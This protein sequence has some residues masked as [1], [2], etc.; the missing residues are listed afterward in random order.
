M[1]PH[2]AIDANYIGCQIV[3]EIY[4]ARARLTEPM[5][6][7]AVAVT[8]VEGGSENVMAISGRMK[9]WGSVRSFDGGMQQRMLGY[10]EKY[11]KSVCEA[12]GA[13]C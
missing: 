1:L 8:R 3:Q 11:A 10:I 2:I 13:K 6:G 12:N 7:M 9:I 4:A 5:S